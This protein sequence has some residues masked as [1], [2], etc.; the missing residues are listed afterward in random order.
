[1]VCDSHLLLPHDREELDDAAMLQ[2]VERSVEHFAKHGVETVF[3]SLGLDAAAGDREGARVS[4]EGFKSATAVL[5][6]RGFNLVLALEGGYHIGDLVGDSLIS[7][8]SSGGV[9]EPEAE[10][11]DVDRF[12][13]TGNF[14]KCVH[15]VALALV[16]KYPRIFKS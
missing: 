8:P 14:G 16:E 7:L 2:A 1:M 13:G 12:L 10:G 4:P 3:V 9:G 6:R 5:R 15:A 11:L